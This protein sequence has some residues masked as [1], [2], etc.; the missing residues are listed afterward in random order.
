MPCADGP[1]FATVLVMRALASVSVLLL[2]T[3][4][5]AGCSQSGGGEGDVDDLAALDAEQSPLESIPAGQV[6]RI[7]AARLNLLSSD[8]A[9][10]EVRAVLEQDNVV[11]AF[12]DSGETGFVHVMVP[13]LGENGEPGTGW[14]TTKY[15]EDTGENR[16]AGFAGVTGGSC[17]PAGGQNVVSRFEKGY[18][19]AIAWAE[20]TRGRAQDGYNVMF[21]Y[22][23]FNSCAQHPNQCLR[24]GRT[25]STA[26]GR[27]QFLTRT[28][29]GA[30]RARRLGSFEPGNQER[31]A[32][33][34][35]A[36]VRR[37][38]IPQDRALTAAEFN[39][40]TSKLSYEW[41]SLPPGRYG[42]PVRTSQQLRT[43]YCE[44]VGCDG[45]NTPTPDSC[46]GKQDA[47]YCSQINTSAA[48]ECR[49]G[50][51]VGATYCPNNKRCRAGSD[52]RA[53]I[54]GGQLGCQ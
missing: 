45:K 3:A 24:F 19:D 8:V 4:L 40:V 15:V 52:G 41:A 22:R 12:E 21:S 2:T 23:L 42:Q 39:N 29:N 35:I 10:S 1:L 46:D 27:Y 6:L 47:Y 11:L 25:C 5:A 49:G 26:A 17:N 14:V 53:Q 37:A 20:G 7:A 44:Q 16:M 50:T 13:D 54:S 32:Q 51:T 28:W 34:L 31:G 30:R 9:G 43:F 18:H 36:N 48:Y 33:Y 38:T